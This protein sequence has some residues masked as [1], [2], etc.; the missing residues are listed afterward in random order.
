MP[1]LRADCL[2]LTPPCPIDE[3]DMWRQN[4]NLGQRPVTGD[5]V[6]EQPYWRKYGLSNETNPCGAEAVDRPLAEI[7][8]ADAD[9]RW[10][11]RA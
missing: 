2:E 4:W 6:A 9:G 1:L 10:R 8:D 3:A 7:A 5:V 11:L